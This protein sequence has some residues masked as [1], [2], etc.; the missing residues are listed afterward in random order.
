V[1]LISF[2]RNL[3]LAYKGGKYSV[4]KNAVEKGKQRCTGY[5]GSIEYLFELKNAASQNQIF[6][7]SRKFKEEYGEKMSLEE[8]NFSVSQPSGEYLRRSIIRLKMS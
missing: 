6:E 7:A 2:L 4:Y 3:N 5:K 1:Q 8:M